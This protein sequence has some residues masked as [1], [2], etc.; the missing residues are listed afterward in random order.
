MSTQAERSYAY[1]LQAKADLET[2]E[3]LS[4]TPEVPQCHR[5]Q[6]LQMACEKLS[7]A[8]AYRFPDVPDDIQTSHAYIAH[9]LP[10]LIGETYR[11][12]KR[13]LNRWERKEIQAFAREIELLSPSVTDGDRRKDNCEYPWDDEAE[14]VQIPVRYSFP[15]LYL[16]SSSVRLLFLKLLPLAISE[17]VDHAP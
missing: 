10:L 15:N 14:V 13:S 4:R 6:F 5:Y 1:A 2:Y 12:H 17:I 8:Y 16:N 9:H 11:R 7:K 3:L